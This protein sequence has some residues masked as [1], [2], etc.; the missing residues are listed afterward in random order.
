[1]YVRLGVGFGGM[2]GKYDYTSSEAQVTE[3]GTTHTLSVSPRGVAGDF[4]VAV[5][6][7]IEPGIAV[8]GEVGTAMF[9]AEHEESLGRTSIE[10]GLAGHVLAIVDYYIERTSPAH[11]SLGG[12]VTRV[13]FASSG[14]NSDGGG[15]SVDVEPVLGGTLVVGAGY[16]V[17][18]GLS[19]DARAMGIYAVESHDRDEARFMAVVLL[20]T[21]GYVWF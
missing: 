20:G 21:A 4:Q 1:M 14:D 3:T 11:V 9:G 6:H 5:G 17:A 13:L 15:P 10:F 2:L 16:L 18:G 8:A 19:L 7:A 12:G